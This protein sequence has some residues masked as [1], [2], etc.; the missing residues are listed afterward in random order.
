MARVQSSFVGVRLTPT[1][2]NALTVF[3]TKHDMKNKKGEPN[4]GEAARTIIAHAFTNGVPGEHLLQAMRENARAEW[5]EKVN[6]GWR[7]AMEALSE[8]GLQE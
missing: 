6:G 4:L 5:F 7:A 2:K 3:A 8:I 1:L